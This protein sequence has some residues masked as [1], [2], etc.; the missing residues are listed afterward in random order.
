MRG[1]HTPLVL[2]CVADVI[3]I[4]LHLEP[5]MTL[6]VQATV[7]QTFGEGLDSLAV[8]RGEDRR[9]RSGDLEVV[10]LSELGTNDILGDSYQ[11]D[12]SVRAYGCTHR[13]LLARPQKEDSVEIH[14][15][16]GVT[17]LG[18][19]TRMEERQIQ[20]LFSLW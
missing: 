6:L 1:K 4:A 16:S 18:L 7:H 12:E 19:L 9:I 17:G 10:T 11:M 8:V 13:Y 5:D 20:N 2:E 14:G 15:M 3:G